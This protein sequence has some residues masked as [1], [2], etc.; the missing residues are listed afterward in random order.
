[1]ANLAQNVGS[2]EASALRLLLN[3]CLQ[4]G[5]PKLHKR[6]VQVVSDQATNKVFV[7]AV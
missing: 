5:F 7:V 1:M 4:A 3:Q 2:F 6:F